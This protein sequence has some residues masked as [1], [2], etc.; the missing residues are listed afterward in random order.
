MGYVT[1]T[2][3]HTHSHT[4]TQ[5]K[6]F[7]RS[8]LHGTIPCSGKAYEYLETKIFLLAKYNMQSLYLTHTWLKQHFALTW[9]QSVGVEFAMCGISKKVQKD[10]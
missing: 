5:R 3:T 1:H 9:Q 4:H 10:S 6:R 7:K 8:G 2:H